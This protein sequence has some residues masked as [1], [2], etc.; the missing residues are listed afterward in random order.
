[1]SG[2]PRPPEAPVALFGSRPLLAV[3]G[4]SFSAGV[5]ARN[6]R[7]GWPYLLARLGGWRVL[8]SA[9]SGAGFLNAGA[10]QRGPLSRLAARID[11]ARLQPALV[12]VQGG[13]NDIGAPVDQITRRV[14][15]L[16]NNLH[17]VDPTA[18]LVILSTFSPNRGATRAGL[19][20]NRAIIRAAQA[21]EPPIVIIDPVA[22]HWSF[23]RTVDGFHP[24]PAGHRW[25]ANRIAADLRRTP[26]TAIVA[27]GH[28][29]AAATPRAI[30]GKDITY[31][32]HAPSPPGA[33]R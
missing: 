4:A 25:I 29:E 20:T 8:V 19:A 22:E 16:I 1:M 12:I 10:G 9:D 23:P 11:F 15:E 31:P 21:A 2:Y 32:R 24:S 3:V 26:R 6:P 14:N 13:F 30:P 7:D 17:R 5:G 27:S 33:R 28:T 18:R